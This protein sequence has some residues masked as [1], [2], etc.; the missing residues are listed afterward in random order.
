MSTEEQKAKVRRA[1][2]EAFNKGNLNALD[3]LMTTGVIVHQPPQPDMKG[4]QAYKQM[5]ADIRKGFSDLKFTID[6]FI[7]EGETDAIRYTA[8]GTHSGQLPNMPIPPTGK[9]VTI[10]GLVMI[11]TVNGK[12]VEQWVYQ[13][14]IGLMQQLGVAPPMGP[15]AK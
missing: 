3:E 12:A 1:I 6:D 10:T 4:P 8:Q 5:V 7:R 9:K 11:H 15:G 14:M 13:D 2:D